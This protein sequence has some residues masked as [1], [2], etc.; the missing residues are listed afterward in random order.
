MTEMI[1]FPTKAADYD[2]ALIYARLGPR[3][4]Q[5]KI[6]LS[7]A[8]F[9]THLVFYSTRFGK[10]PS[11]LSNENVTWTARALSA[12]SVSAKIQSNLD[13]LAECEASRVLLEPSMPSNPFRKHL[14]ETVNALGFLPS[15][16]S[17]VGSINRLSQ[18][19]IFRDS[20]HSTLAFI[21]MASAIN[22]L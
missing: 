19:E 9:L 21:L 8:Y 20:Y 3:S 16:A 15:N 5:R 4:D 1:E 10:R 6:T 18:D 22:R 11:A 12:I 17:M 2:T 13:L 14:T 7:D